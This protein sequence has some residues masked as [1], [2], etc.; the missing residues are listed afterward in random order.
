MIRHAFTI[1]S[2]LALA[3][4][5]EG[6]QDERSQRQ[7]QL[8]NMSGIVIALESMNLNFQDSGYPSSQTQIQ[9]YADVQYVLKLISLDQQAST[10]GLDGLAKSVPAGTPNCSDA[11]PSVTEAP[12]DGLSH[13]TAEGNSRKI[14]DAVRWPCAGRFKICYRKYVT[15]TWEMLPQTIDVRGEFAGPQTCTGTY[16]RPRLEPPPE[17]GE[18]GHRCWINGTSSM[19]GTSGPVMCSGSNEFA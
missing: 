18:P 12:L 17:V 4:A 14:F 10:L 6:T 1:L 16:A 11:T 7:L 8:A 9:A 19:S 13:P 2:T 15:G 3:S 5:E